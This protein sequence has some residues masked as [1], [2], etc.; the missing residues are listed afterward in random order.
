MA[1]VV[2][3]CEQ[4]EIVPAGKK[5]SITYGSAKGAD[6]RFDPQ[7]MKAVASGK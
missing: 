6:L 2:G 5:P 3:F 4:A 7:Y 1:K